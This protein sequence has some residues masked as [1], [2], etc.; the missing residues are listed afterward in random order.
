[1]RD[2]YVYLSEV[3]AVWT[4]VPTHSDKAKPKRLEKLAHGLEAADPVY[5][6]QIERPSMLGSAFLG[7]EIIDVYVELIVFES[8]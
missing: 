4:Y 3:L 6:V 1:M 7:E 2:K 8:V 5:V